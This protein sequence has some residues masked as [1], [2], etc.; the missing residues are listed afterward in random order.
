MWPLAIF[1]FAPSSS[2]CSLTGDTVAR[3]HHSTPS[4]AL[5]EPINVVRFEFACLP[6]RPHDRRSECHVHVFVRAPIASLVPCAT[7]TPSIATQ[8]RAHRQVQE[9]LCTRVDAPVRNVDVTLGL[10]SNRSLQR[11][12]WQHAS[13][14]L[15][16]SLLQQRCLVLPPSLSHSARCRGGIDARWTC[17]VSSLERRVEQPQ[18]PHLCSLRLVIVRAHEAHELHDARNDSLGLVGRHG[19]E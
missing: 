4:S 15:A 1:H 14:R 19:L 18:E 12:R 16:W 2:F 7:R 13:R 5:Y 17:R 11:S 6:P 9:I 8:A 3:A 10:E